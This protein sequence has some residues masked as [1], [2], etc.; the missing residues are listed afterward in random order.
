VTAQDPPPPVELIP[1]TPSPLSVAIQ[2]STVFGERGNLRLMLQLDDRGIA[3]LFDGREL[4][5]AEEP[6]PFDF[7]AF[8][9]GAVVEVRPAVAFIDDQP[10][11]QTDPVP[12][13]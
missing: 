5:G 12:G 7:A 13:P 8:D 9:A 11:P 4:V 10:S 1:F 6:Q 3:P 2:K